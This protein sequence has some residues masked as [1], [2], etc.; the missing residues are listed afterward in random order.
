MP[1]VVLLFVFT[2]RLAPD[3]WSPLISSVLLT[4]YVEWGIW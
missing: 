2:V 3:S 4:N 1:S